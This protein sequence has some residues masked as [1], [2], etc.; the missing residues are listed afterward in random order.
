LLYLARPS[1]T[2]KT[3]CVIVEN[4]QNRKTRLKI[5]TIISRIK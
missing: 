3:L 5:E 2:S 1:P 4:Q